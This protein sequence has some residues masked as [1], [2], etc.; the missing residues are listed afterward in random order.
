MLGAFNL[1]MLSQDA[2]AK[3]KIIS[4]LYE[5]KPNP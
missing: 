4:L 5:I 3:D 1:V 2:T